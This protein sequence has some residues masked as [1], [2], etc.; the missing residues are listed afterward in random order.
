MMMNLLNI[1]SGLSL[2]IK[3]YI[4]D[5]DSMTTTRY[6]HTT[7][8]AAKNLAGLWEAYYMK[9]IHVSFSPR[10][11]YVLFILFSYLFAHYN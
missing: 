2:P 4:T 3:C 9:S 7:F 1:A 6:M 5:M 8:T 11:L 10:K